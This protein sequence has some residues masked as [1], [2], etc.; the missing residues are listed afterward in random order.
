MSTRSTLTAILTARGFGV[1]DATAYVARLNDAQA[2]ADLAWH[3]REQTWLDAGPY[4]GWSTAQRQAVNAHYLGDPHYVDP[5]YL[6]TT[7][8]GER[9]QAPQET[10]KS[11]T[12]VVVAGLAFVALVGAAAWAAGRKR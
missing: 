6:L 12:G 8:P 4:S 11:N 7:Y 1:D 5:M 10:P 2:T 3:D 9:P